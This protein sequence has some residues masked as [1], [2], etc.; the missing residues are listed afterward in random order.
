M[1]NSQAISMEGLKVNFSRYFSVRASTYHVH[2]PIILCLFLAFLGT[3]GG[4][5]SFSFFRPLLKE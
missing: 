4:P 3:V 2:I 5:C 1:L